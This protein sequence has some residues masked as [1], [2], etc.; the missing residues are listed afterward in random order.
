MTMFCL[1]ALIRGG[2]FSKETNNGQTVRDD[3]LNGEIP[4]VL[5]ACSIVPCLVAGCDFILSQFPV[6]K[7]LQVLCSI[8]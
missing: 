3:D 5:K 7:I 4:S 2:R 1:Y 8:C 6:C